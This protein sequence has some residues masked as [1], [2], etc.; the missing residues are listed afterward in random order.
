MYAAAS[1]TT[2]A[3]TVIVGLVASTVLPVMKRITYVPGVDGIA[4]LNVAPA[5][6]VAGAACVPF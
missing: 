5:R 1:E 2:L 3:D 4:T 6:P